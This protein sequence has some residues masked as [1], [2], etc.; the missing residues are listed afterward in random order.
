MTTALDERARHAA[1]AL[2]EAARDRIGEVASPAVKGRRAPLLVAI[3]A[4]SVAFVVLVS[5]AVAARDTESDDGRVTT[6]PSTPPTNVEIVNRWSVA[7]GH[8][9]ITSDGASVWVGG[10]PTPCRDTLDCDV[11]ALIQRVDTTTGRSTTFPVDRHDYPVHQTIHALLYAFDSLWVEAADARGN[12]NVWRLDPTTGDV[13]ASFDVVA[14]QMVA[15]ESAVWGVGSEL[16][17]IDPE[18][19]QMRRLP[20]VKI[21]DQSLS[22]AS[23]RAV[24]GGIVYELFGSFGSQ[25]T[26]PPPRALVFAP[27]NGEPRVLEPSTGRAQWTTDDRFVWRL[28]RRDGLERHDVESAAPPA[29]FSLEPGMNNVERVLAR[30]PLVVSG[31]VFFFDPRGT[32]FQFDPTNPERVAT[33]KLSEWQTAQRPHG[34][35]VTWETRDRGGFWVLIDGGVFQLSGP[36]G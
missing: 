12:E 36:T 33:H 2:H 31:N 4:V 8:T 15:T 20:L 32:V 35:F 25:S 10:A 30:E 34:D 14:S 16:W 19:G 24:K 22:G 27:E 21:Q 26:T 6:P 29:R 5:V 9:K 11:A 7:E 28:D 13:Q 23:L 1:D 18:T 17:R 3:A